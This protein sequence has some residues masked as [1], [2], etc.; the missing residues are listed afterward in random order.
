MLGKEPLLSLLLAD[1]K[2]LYDFTNLLDPHVLCL[3]S[4]K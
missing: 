2:L 1:F 3:C 4:L